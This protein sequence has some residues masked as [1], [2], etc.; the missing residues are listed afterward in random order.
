MGLEAIYIFMMNKQVKE[1]KGSEIRCLSLSSVGNSGKVNAGCNM[2]CTLSYGG[3]ANKVPAF[4][5]AKC[6]GKL[7][8]EKRKNLNYNQSK[9]YRDWECVKSQILILR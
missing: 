9:E 1:K 4:S 3:T 7:S 6:Q 5:E 2:T 8:Q